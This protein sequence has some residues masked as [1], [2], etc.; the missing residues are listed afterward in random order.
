MTKKIKPPRDDEILAMI[1]A[2]LDDV[3]LA[4]AALQIPLAKMQKRI[5]TKPLQGKY[6][7]LVLYMA[8]GNVSVAA[9]RIGLSRQQLY[10]CIE[11]DPVIAKGKAEGLNKRLD[12]AES[13]LEK[14]ILAGK[15][16]SIFFFLKCQGKVR[17]YIER[18]EITGA[19]GAA[20][21]PTTIRLEY[22]KPGKAKKT[23]KK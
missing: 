9:K 8:G 20:L 12:F 11:A 21:A 14:N 19:D 18:Q 17:G 10:K 3:K 5:K 16:A 13:Q 22:V 1:E 15:E 2:Q 23:S 6:R 4:A 7:A